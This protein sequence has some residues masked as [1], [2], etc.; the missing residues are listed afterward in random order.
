MTYRFNPRFALLLYLIF[1]IGCVF[2]NNYK[3]ML[4]LIFT[5]S[6]IAYLLFNV[7]FKKYFIRFFLL[8]P[9]FSFFVGFFAIFN[10]IT[11]GNML[12]KFTENFYI[13]DRGV[14]AFLHF[15]LRILLISSITGIYVMKTEETD[16]L[17]A[18][19]SLHL[20]GEFVLI[21]LLTLRYIKIFLKDIED[22]LNAKKI[23]IIVPAG[24]PGE[25]RWVGSR[26]FLLFEKGLR[27]S[28]EVT[29]GLVLRGAAGSVKYPEPEK[30]KGTE[31]ILII[32]TGFTMAGI[33]IIDRLL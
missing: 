29:R 1:L 11:P 15:Y 8:L 10:F 3:I 23:R 25:I 21:F 22:F 18:F 26:A 31:L 17:R 19:K 24:F 27:D 6:T 5:A 7:D 30:M 4:L 32:L 33:L 20:P 16:F 14:R 13:T 9:L 2:L 12:L 28:I